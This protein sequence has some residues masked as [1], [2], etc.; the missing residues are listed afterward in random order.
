MLERIGKQ[1]AAAD[2]A[3]THRSGTVLFLVFMWTLS[4]WLVASTVADRLHTLDTMKLADVEANS[5]VY[6]YE[7]ITPTR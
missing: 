1:L 4:G 2:Q 6:A 7:R 5:F 3:R